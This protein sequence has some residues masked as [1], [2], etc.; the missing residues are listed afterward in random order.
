MEEPG[1]HPRGPDHSR[2]VLC[3]GV[4]N[5][6]SPWGWSD[7]SLL[8]QA[9]LKVGTDQDQTAAGSWRGGTPNTPAGS[10]DVQSRQGGS[11]EGAGRPRRRRRD[12]NPGPAVPGVPPPAPFAFSCSLSH[13]LKGEKQNLEAAVSAPR[14][15]NTHGGAASSQARGR[16][17]PARGSLTRGH[18]VVTHHGR[19]TP[20]HC[21][22]LY[23]CGN[24]QKDAKNVE[25]PY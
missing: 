16:C 17:P 13:R 24:F 7:V 3:L 23:A 22:L 20:Q 21:Q 12:S 18:Y 2:G 5:L 15:R 10:P 8:A 9:P 25:G 14:K 19:G 11:A 1:E 6:L 4:Q